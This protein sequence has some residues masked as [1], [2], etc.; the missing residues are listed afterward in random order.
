M[1]AG[2]GD[3]GDGMADIFISYAREDRATAERLAQLLESGT[4]WRVFWDREIVPGASFADVIAAELKAARHVLVLWSQA[5]IGSRWVRD[6]AQEG[7]NRN[8]LT[9]VLIEA[10]EPPLGFRSI[11]AADLTGWERGADDPRFQE[12]LAALHG[13][14]SAA[15]VAAP[16]PRPGPAGGR[17]RRR[18]V[19]AAIVLGGIAVA[20]LGLRLFADRL[21]KPEA[22]RPRTLEMPAGVRA[23]ARFRD[24][25][26]C[27]EMVALP[28][29]RVVIGASWFDR[30]AQS[31]ER[32]RVDIDIARPFALAATE[33]TFDDWL[34][35]VAAGGCR[36]YRPDDEGWGQGRQPV[37]YVSWDQ[38]NQYALWLSERTGRAYRLPSEAEW[39][40]ACQAG[41]LT[42]YAVGE[43]IAA[44]QANF[45]RNAAGTRPAG[46]FP[47]NPWGLF[48]MHGN[49]WEWV[50]DT[51]AP[52]HRGRP[53]DGRARD[54]AAA[55]DDRTIRGGSWDDP[56]RRVRCIAR[57]H[58]DRD[59]R[60]NE[61]G[62]RVARDF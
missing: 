47:G 40:Y 10:V 43:T 18:A 56:P 26:T 1:A 12:L 5:S 14:P 36:G 51:W 34:A 53:G 57:D 23:F 29:G 54:E 46:S 13:P 17:W 28:P 31:D 19:I 60:E 61:I 49:V 48:D 45:G 27:P 25:P 59:Q 15:A 9:P 44:D 7:A 2:S 6:E 58:K 22:F 55:G 38:A 62:F 21:A 24:C 39:E 20:A 8:T 11:H 42:R 52:S 4:G 30:E 41:S 3:G 16:A 32:P 33:I 50:A 37:I 35:C